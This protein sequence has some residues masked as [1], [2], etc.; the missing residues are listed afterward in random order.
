MFKIGE[1][2]KSK[3]SKKNLN[4]TKIGGKCINFAEIGEFVILLEIGE[5][6]ICF[7]DLRGWT[8]VARFRQCIL[9]G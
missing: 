1:S 6:A 5:Y 3:L 8:P 4:F 7:I 2:K 9:W